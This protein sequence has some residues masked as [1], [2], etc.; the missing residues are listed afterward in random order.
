MR[1]R[2]FAVLTIFVLAAGCRPAKP[3]AVAPP[4]AKTAIETPSPDTNPPPPP[5][6]AAVPSVDTSTDQPTIKIA[7]W[8]ETQQL[9]AQNT[10]KVVI[11]D[12]WASW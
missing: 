8:E 2:A 5:I 9:V 3:V 1:L 6:R 11:L 7:S 12:L 10:G 4:A